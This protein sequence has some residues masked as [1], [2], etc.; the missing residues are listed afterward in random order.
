[1]SEN[2]RYNGWANYET[3]AVKLWM[4]N[5]PGEYEHWRETAQAVWNDTDDKATK[6]IHGS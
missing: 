5:D 3:W 1:M 2:K 6:R 4:D